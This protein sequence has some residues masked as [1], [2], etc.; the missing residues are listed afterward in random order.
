MV[1]N[2]EALDVFMYKNEQKPVDLAVF[3]GAVS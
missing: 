1:V 2:K 3:Y